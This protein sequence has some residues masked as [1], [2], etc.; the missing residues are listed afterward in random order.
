MTEKAKVALK[1]RGPVHECHCGYRGDHAQM[2]EHLV[3]RHLG[4]DRVPYYCGPSHRP[5]RSNAQAQHHL[6]QRHE[7]VTSYKMFLLALARK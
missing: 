6:E 5:F 7:L 1:K 3:K 2:L 4:N